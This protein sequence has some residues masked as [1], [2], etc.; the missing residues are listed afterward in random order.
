MSPTT[1]GWLLWFFCEL[2]SEDILSTQALEGGKIHTTAIDHDAGVVF[3]TSLGHGC[4]GCHDMLGSV[5]RPFCAPAEDNMEIL[6]AP[7][8]DDRGQAVLSYTH[9]CMG[10]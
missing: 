6:V 7:C 9:E 5:V 2:P 1:L 8:L 10:V 3:G 4:R